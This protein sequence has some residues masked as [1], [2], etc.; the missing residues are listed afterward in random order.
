[1]YYWST[2]AR[3]SP[4]RH[5]CTEQYGYLGL[6]RDGKP[7]ELGSSKFPV[8]VCGV[9]QRLDYYDRGSRPGI[10]K[11]RMDLSMWRADAPGVIRPTGVGICAIDGQRPS[12]E[13]AVSETNQKRNS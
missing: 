9:V 3:R 11:H 7:R 2:A 12:S 10:L 8:L 6:T 1:M 13:Q 4:C 5:D